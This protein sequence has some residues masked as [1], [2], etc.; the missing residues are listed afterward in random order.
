MIKK[1]KEDYEQ[2]KKRVEVD[3][4]R[5]K[6]LQ[7]L[8]KLTKTKEIKKADMYKRKKYKKFLKQQKYILKI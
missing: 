4:R 8:E 3:S 5:K 6:I 7:K 1:N 2:Q